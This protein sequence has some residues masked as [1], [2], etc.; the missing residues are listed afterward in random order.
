MPTSWDQDDGWV[1]VPSVSTIGAGH[2]GALAPMADVV[3]PSPVD[4]AVPDA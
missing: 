1:Q 2:S 4:P 3:D